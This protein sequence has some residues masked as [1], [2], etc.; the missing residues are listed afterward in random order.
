MQIAICDE[1]T[2]GLTSR[3]DSYFSVLYLGGLGK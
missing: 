1:F 2:Q 3:I